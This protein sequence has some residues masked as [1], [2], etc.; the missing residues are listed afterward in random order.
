MR[1][2]RLK[3]RKHKQ[4]WSNTDVYKATCGKFV[5]YA[6]HNGTKV[7]DPGGTSFWIEDTNWSGRVLVVSESMTQTSIDLAKLW[8][9]DALVHH[10]KREHRRVLNVKKALGVS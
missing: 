9:E 7:R 5:L 8:A 1:T 6:A 10:V 3:W 4:T 2:L